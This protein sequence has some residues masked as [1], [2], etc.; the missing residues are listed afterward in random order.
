MWTSLLGNVSITCFPFCDVIN[1]EVKI[2]F[3]IKPFSH[4]IEEHFFIILKVLS[5]KQIKPT[6]LEGKSPT[7]REYRSSHQRCSV[8]KG[9][10][11]NFAKIKGKHLCQS[12]FFNK[13]KKQTLAQVLYCEFCEIFKNTFF[14]EYLW[15]T[16]FRDLK[17]VLLKCDF[18]IIAHFL[19]T[20]IVFGILNKTQ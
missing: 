7:L 3:F 1:S 18:Y 12:L 6:F 13:V 4:I 5:F 15:A 19:L 16:A 17:L 14:T 11:R 2:S 10:L 20:F 8:R 9:V